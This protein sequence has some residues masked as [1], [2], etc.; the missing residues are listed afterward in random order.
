M[1]KKFIPNWTEKAPEPYSYRS[2][3]KWGDP[4]TFKHPNPKLY[5]ELKEIFIEK[6]LYQAIK[7]K[8]AII[9]VT[10]HSN[11]KNLD[12]KKVKI[13]MKNLIIIDGRNIINK[14]IAEKLGF[15]YKGVGKWLKNWDQG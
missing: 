5:E 10:A 6:N 1:A 4:N 14:K 12:L 2:I 3:F 15:V 7:N 11:Y 8:D 13:F 9:I